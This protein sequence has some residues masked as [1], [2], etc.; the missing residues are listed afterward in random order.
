MKVLEVEG[1]RSSVT[2]APVAKAKGPGF[3]SLVTTEIFFTFCIC[4]SLD[5]LSE[6]VSNLGKEVHQFTILL[7]KVTKLFIRNT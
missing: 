1:C 2:R 4:F 5:P 6:E 7:V 3:D